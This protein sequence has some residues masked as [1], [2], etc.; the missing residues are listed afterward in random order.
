VD[1][2]TGAVNTFGAAMETLGGVR[3]ASSS[4]SGI[5]AAGAGAGEGAG[6][7]GSGA[8]TSGSG[9]GS[10]A[11]SGTAGATGW[12]GMSG[13]ASD[14]ACGMG[15]LCAVSAGVMVD[16]LTGTLSAMDVGSCTTAGTAVT[17]AGASAGMGMGAAA[18]AGLSTGAGVRE[19][20]DA[21]STTPA[22][23]AHFQPATPPCGCA[24]A[25]RS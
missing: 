12:T 9:M 23:T 25:W 2:G 19:A 11:G 3:A 20:Q 6:A 16:A 21:S 14:T 10:M 22:R 17:L 15:R 18:A 4:V 13:S 5:A 8:G 1:C 7:G 24:T